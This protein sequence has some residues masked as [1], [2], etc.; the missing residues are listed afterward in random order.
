ML[1]EAV[2]N[3]WVNAIISVIAVVG[4]GT[5]LY[6]LLTVPSQKEKWSLKQTKL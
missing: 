3:T 4:G 1:S 2:V 5:G 6:A